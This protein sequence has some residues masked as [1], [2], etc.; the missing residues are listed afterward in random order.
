MLS[1][2]YENKSLDFLALIIVAAVMLAIIATSYL[3]Q[4]DLV[5]ASE[6]SMT[7]SVKI[8][9]CTIITSP[10]L[11]ILAQ[12]ISGTHPG[13]DWCIKI[14][15]SNVVINGGGYSIEAVR[16]VGVFIESADNVTVR[17]TRITGSNIGIRIL[18]SSRSIIV[19]N[20]IANN[21]DGIWILNSEN[22]TIVNNTIVN[23]KW[24]GIRLVLYS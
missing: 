17:N 23:N 16:G 18:N 4:R 12:N 15:A 11:Y 13:E 2:R 3:A 8:T 5:E 24:S 20:I 6:S 19:S 9:E 21:R 7:T 1:I 10:G 14:S 22:N